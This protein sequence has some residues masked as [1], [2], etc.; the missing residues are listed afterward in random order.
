MWLSS[1]DKYQEGI[2]GKYQREEREA[3]RGDREVC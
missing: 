3:E 1:W 2:E